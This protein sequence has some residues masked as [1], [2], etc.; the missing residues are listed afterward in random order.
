MDKKDESGGRIVSSLAG[1]PRISWG[2]ISHAVKGEKSS[3]KAQSIDV[4]VREKNT[5]TL[6]VIIRRLLEQ[7][8]ARTSLCGIAK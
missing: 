4:R 2:G 6:C 3:P 1:W 5:V 8:G 7:N